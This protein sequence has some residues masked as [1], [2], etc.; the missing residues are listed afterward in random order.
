[1]L[2]EEGQVVLKEHIRDV[3]SCIDSMAQAIQREKV[4]PGYEAQRQR[5]GCKNGSP[6]ALEEQQL[7]FRKLHR[8]IESG[9]A[10][11]ARWDANVGWAAFSEADQNTFWKYWN[12]DLQRELRECAHESRDK[13]PRRLEAFSVSK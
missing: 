9:I 7:R 13:G 1:M 12:G 3:L 10:L 11:L 5:S 2:S 6:L 8:D 4:T